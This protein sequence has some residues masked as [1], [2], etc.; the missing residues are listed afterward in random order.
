MLPVVQH[1]TSAV[2]CLFI[3]L[4]LARLIHLLILYLS[5]YLATKIVAFDFPLIFT[6]Y[7]ILHGYRL[8]ARDFPCRTH[9]A[10]VMAPFWVDYGRHGFGA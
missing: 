4:S 5:H 9:L 7:T 6:V 2:R 1:H 10:L 3:Y 8:I